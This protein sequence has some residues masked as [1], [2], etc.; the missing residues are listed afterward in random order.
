ML[1]TRVALP[2]APPRRN[3]NSRLALETGELVRARAGDEASTRFHHAISRAY[4]DEGE[5]ISDLGVV[6]RYAVREGVGDADLRAVWMTHAYAS[7]IR[8]SMH[9]ARIAGVRGVPAYGWPGARALSGM[10]EPERIVAALR[11][12][13]PRI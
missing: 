13:A 7:A 1:A 12:L 2:I 3:V 6:A 10:L 9:A 11:T 5:D 8:E 4:F